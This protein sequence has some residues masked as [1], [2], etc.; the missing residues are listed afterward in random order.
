MLN[1]TEGEL[2]TEFTDPI[3]FR[4]MSSITPSVIIENMQEVCRQY[5]IPAVFEEATLTE[6]GASSV[7]ESIGYGQKPS[8]FKAFHKNVY[9]A[10]RIKHS[11][12]PQPYCDQLYVLVRD[13]IRFFYVGASKAFKERNEYERGLTGDTS[14]MSLKG[15][16][17]AYTGIRPDEDAYN[18]E[19]EWHMNVYAAFESL[20]ES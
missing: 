20:V 14:G 6:G 10:V 5:G 9:P 13:G 7:L 11:N 12:P 19:M 4:D 18:R 17:R 3:G 2:G 8:L 16:L 1:Y 15:K